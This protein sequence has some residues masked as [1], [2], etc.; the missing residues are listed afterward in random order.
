[1]INHCLKLCSINSNLLDPVMEV[2]KYTCHFTLCATLI[3]QKRLPTEC[4]NHWILNGALLVLSWPEV[5]FLVFVHIAVC[6]RA[7][8][9]FKNECIHFKNNHNK[10]MH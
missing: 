3:K 1:M 6:V 4:P 8:T 7:L 10:G 9:A 5:S 2:S